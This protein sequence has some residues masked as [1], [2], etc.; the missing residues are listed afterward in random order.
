[1]V[2]NPTP[3]T[4][5][6][7]ANSV[8]HG[9]CCVA[10]KRLDT[11]EWVRPVSNANGAELTYQQA[12]ARNPYGVYKVKPLQMVQMGFEQA[13]PLNN[14]PEN[15]L[16][17]R[18]QWIQQYNIVP[19]E[20]NQFLDE[21]ESLWG[22]GDRVDY[23]AIMRDQVA[24]EQSLQLVKVEQLMLYVDGQNKRRASF[25]YNGIGYDLA[26]TDPNFGH[27]VGNQHD[28]MGILCISLG[29]PFQGNCYKLVA[30]IY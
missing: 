26:V 4:L 15:Q 5:V 6:I 20:I 11:R 12:S 8:K 18:E 3:C 19:A 2:N 17:N 21:P 7:F 13:V 23:Q 30:A 29:E 9:Q 1:M 27:L 22:S 16:I 24:I 25:S 10:G 28:L 14:Q